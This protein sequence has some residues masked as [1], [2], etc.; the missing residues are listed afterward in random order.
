MSRARRLPSFTAIRAFEAAARC[1]SFKEASKELHVTP[2]AISHQ[3]KTLEEFLGV[4]L[5]LRAA[6]RIVLTRSGRKYLNELSGLLDRLDAATRQAAR[7]DPDDDPLTILCTPGFAARWLAPNLA[8]CPGSD[9]IEVTICEDRPSS[10]F[11]RNG[12]DLVIAWGHW[13]APGT[14]WEVLMESGT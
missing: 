4:T 13:P 6:N 3:V 14:I 9:R 11:T 5:F 7:T 1:L 8:E 12:A 10:D 2:S